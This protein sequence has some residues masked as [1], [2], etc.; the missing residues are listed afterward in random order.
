VARLGDSFPLPVEVTPFAL[1]PVERALGALGAEPRLRERD[2]SP[3][4]TDNGNWLVDLR[5]RGGIADP[6][7]L[8]RAIDAVPGV[9]ESG[10]FIAMANRIVIA[11]PEAIE[12]RDVR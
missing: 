3:F 8:E 4:V 6:A 9:V 10:L 5:F 1:R 12:V 2:G 11:R 7:A